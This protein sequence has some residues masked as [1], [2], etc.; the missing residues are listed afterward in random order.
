[1]RAETRRRGPSESSTANLSMMSLHSLSG[2]SII[3]Y[4]QL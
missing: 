3:M 2:K 4:L 1:M